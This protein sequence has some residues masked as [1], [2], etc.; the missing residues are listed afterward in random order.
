MAG[1]L[2]VVAFRKTANKDARIGQSAPT[3]FSRKAPDA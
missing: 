3:L 1:T 2:I